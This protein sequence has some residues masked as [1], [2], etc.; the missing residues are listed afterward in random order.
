ME[1]VPASGSRYEECAAPSVHEGWPYDLGPGAGLDI[2]TFIEDD[3]VPS[4]TPE[5]VGVI[6]CS[7]FDEAARGVVNLFL[8]FENACARKLSGDLAHGAPAFERLLV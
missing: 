6:G 3:E 2:T 5:A 8:A 7:C 4:T 1:P